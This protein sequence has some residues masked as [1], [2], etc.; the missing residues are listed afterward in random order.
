M[1]VVL[2]AGGLGTRLAEETGTRPKPMVEI[3]GRPILWHIMKQ[4]S[5]AG[6]NEF[7]VCLGYKGYVIKEY[8]ANYLLHMDDVTFD[9]AAGRIEYLG[10]K[11]REPWRV[12]LIDTGLSTET[13]GRV[14]RLKP[15]LE[16]GDAF[17]LTYGDG[18]GNVKD[19]AIDLRNNRA[20]FLVFGGQVAGQS[21]PV[22]HGVGLD[23]FSFDDPESVRIETDRAALAR[24]KGIDLGRLPS[25]PSFTPPAGPK[26]IR[27]PE[28]ATPPARD[29]GAPGA[30]RPGGSGSGPR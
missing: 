18:L 28:K 8:F 14:K 29:S 25:K 15:L 4:Y 10:A 1:K 24:S 21:E 27:T 23:S 12:T 19:L 17:C 30:P 20:A 11:G 9:L 16:N 6:L 26:V 13:G 7:I 22:F 3:G 2:L 5:Q